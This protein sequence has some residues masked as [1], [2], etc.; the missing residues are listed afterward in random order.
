MHGQVLNHPGAFN[1]R[2]QENGCGIQIGLSNQL[3]YAL[4]DTDSLRNDFC[5]RSLNGSEGPSERFLTDVHVNLH[6]AW[7]AE[8]ECAHEFAAKV[9][10]VMG[11]VDRR[12]VAVWHGHDYAV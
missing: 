5:S 8:I 12:W 6:R 9:G 10:L 3:T 7:D 11:Q 2:S 4:C 1:K